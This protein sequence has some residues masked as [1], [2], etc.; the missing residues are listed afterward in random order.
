MPQ[1]LAFTITKQGAVI[2]A[3]CFAVMFPILC[4]EQQ[5]ERPTIFPALV[6]PV[7]STHQ[8]ALK[9]SQFKS[10]VCA[11]FHSDGPTIWAT[12][13]ELIVSTY[14][15]AVAIPDSYAIFLAH[16]TSF[17]VSDIATYWTAECNAY[18]HAQQHSVECSKWLSHWLANGTANSVTFKHS[19]LG[20][21]WTSYWLSY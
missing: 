10:D 19:E 12:V 4:S 9:G 8:Q 15:P 7:R 3:F 6:K 14:G 20:S 18:L 21:H 17:W 1:C 5:S 16:W 13:T 2:N 11:N